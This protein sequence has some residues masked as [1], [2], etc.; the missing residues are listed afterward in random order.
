MRWLLVLLTISVIFPT[1]S[2]ASLSKSIDYGWN[3]TFDGKLY[4]DRP[5]ENR[6]TQ[7]VQNKN[8][9]SVQ[10]DSVLEPFQLDS[11]ISHS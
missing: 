8:F 1:Q 4:Q 2:V 7:F 9:T 11:K 3:I 6:W 5:I 10:Y